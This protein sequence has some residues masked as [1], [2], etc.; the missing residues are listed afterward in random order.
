MKRCRAC[1]V[2]IEGDWEVCPLCRG[3]VEGEATTSPL[4]RVPLVFS[5][6]RVLRVLFVCSLVVILGSF[7]IQLLFHRGTSGIGVLRSIWLGVVAGWLV[8]LMA[9]RKRRNAAKGT[10]YLVLVVG[11][12][13]AYWD[14]L[15]GWHGWSLSY[16]VPIVCASSIAA[17]LIAVRVMRMEVGDHIVYSGLIGLL[18]LVPILFL[19]FGWAPNPIAS[20]VCVA[21]S[22]VGLMRMLAWFPEARRELAKRLRL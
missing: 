22:A 15:T 13:S 12:V 16:V 10:V 1:R 7:A 3:P 20:W 9:V 21:I 2:S 18:G 19:V 4:P 8:V 11:G 17:V 5:R 6:R 14:Y